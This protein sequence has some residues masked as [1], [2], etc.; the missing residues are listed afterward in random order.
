L[1]EPVAD[2]IHGLAEMGRGRV[3]LKLGPQPAHVDVNGAC[4]AYRVYAPY[5]IKKR[6]TGEDLH[7]VR[8]QE[9]E[10]LYLRVKWAW[11]S[12]QGLEP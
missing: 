8:C 6:L 7:G 4:A 10:Q 3:V 2:A 1:I 12:R 11:V 9:R 5:S